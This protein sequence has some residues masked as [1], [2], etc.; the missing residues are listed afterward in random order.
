MTSEDSTVTEIVSE[1]V[2]A[3]SKKKVRIEGIGQILD[4]I[5]DETGLQYHEIG[6]Q[7]LEECVEMGIT[8][9]GPQN[10]PIEV[11]AKTRIWEWC[12]GS[13]KIPDWLVPVIIN[14][15]LK[16]FLSETDTRERDRKMKKM[17]TIVMKTM[18][19]SCNLNWLMLKSLNISEQKIIELINEKS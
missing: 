18:I 3:E 8:R 16:I 1:P 2:K 4:M 7:L 19:S 13:R 12:K 17:R 6:K 10:K 11:T 15:A 14:W 9:W 5:R